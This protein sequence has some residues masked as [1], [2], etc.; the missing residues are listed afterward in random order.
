MD[1]MK[2]GTELL[3]NQL[4]NRGASADENGIAD[5][6]TSLLGGS[7]GNLDL[8]G[9]VSKFMGNSD[10]S[11]MVASWLGDGDNDPISTD[12]VSQIFDS[13]TIADFASKLGLDT[14]SATETIAETLPQM[15]DKS[16]SGGSLLDAVGGVEGALNMARKFFN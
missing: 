8:G 13:G 14:G 3:M 4:S 11:G 6:L 9:L 16:S 1:L 12:Q 7:D 2:L 15:V 10:L 5:A